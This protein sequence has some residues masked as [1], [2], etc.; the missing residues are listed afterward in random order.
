MHLRG[1][2]QKNIRL[3]DTHSQLS[4]RRC[5]QQVWQQTE[6]CTYTH[7]STQTYMVPGCNTAQLVADQGCLLIPHFRKLIGA[8]VVFM[9]DSG[10]CTLILLCQ[11]WQ[12][13]YYS[14]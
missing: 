1:T 13:N 9:K 4:H 2:E 10:I 11:Y 5:G 3:A 7:M 12:S 8:G 14:C 6:E